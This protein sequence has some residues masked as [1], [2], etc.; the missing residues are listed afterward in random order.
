MHWGSRFASGSGINVLT[1]GAF[2]PVSKQPELKHAAVQV[3][4]LAMARQMTA[5]R[6]V[7]DPLALMRQLAPFLN[8]STTRPSRRP[9]RHAR[10]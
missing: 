1:T 10:R 9:A 5:M 7:D 2:D 3:T 4:R 8:A 6:A